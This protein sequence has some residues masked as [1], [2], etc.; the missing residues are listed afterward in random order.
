M[1]EKLPTGRPLSEKEVENLREMADEFTSVATRKGCI[2]FVIGFEGIKTIGFHYA[3]L[4][5][6]WVE[7]VIA[8]KSDSP[9]DE[10]VQR[11]KDEIRPLMKEYQRID[12]RKGSDYD[13][14]TA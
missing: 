3:V 6:K 13:Y 8:E 9:H 4:E 1:L 14:M 5:G 2:S 12:E 10:T 7:T 11:H